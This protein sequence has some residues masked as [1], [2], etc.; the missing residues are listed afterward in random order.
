MRL[1]FLVPFGLLAVSAAASAQSTA[2]DPYQWLE[3]WTTPRVM[4][5]V[6]AHNATTVKRLEAD[7]RY[8]ELYDQ[9]L[10]IAGAKDRIPAPAFRHGEIFNFWQDPEHLRGIWRK[11]SLADYRNA[12]PNWTTVLDIDALNQAEGKS[13]VFKGAAC[14]PP[15]E[16][17]CLI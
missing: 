11:T 12:A 3:E 4:E 13:F 5:W 9:A 16:K 8:A 10:A 1:G 7:P 2:D 15:D 14:L 6:E 17:R